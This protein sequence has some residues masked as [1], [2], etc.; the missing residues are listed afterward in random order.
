MIARQLEKLAL[1]GRCQTCPVQEICGGGLYAHRYQP[2]GG[3]ARPSVYCPDLFKLIGHIGDTMWM[4][5]ALRDK[6]AKAAR[7]QIYRYWS[8]R[9]YGRK[10]SLGR[11]ISNLKLP[12]G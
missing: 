10:P 1:G 11:L 5:P 6:M 3:F 2:G 4:D 12:A 8:R 9:P 7:L